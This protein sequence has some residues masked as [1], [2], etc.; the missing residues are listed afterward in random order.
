MKIELSVKE[1]E[2]LGH[3]HYWLAMGLGSGTAQL[4]N[5]ER[6]ELLQKARHWFERAYIY[7]GSAASKRFADSCEQTVSD[8][9]PALYA[10]AS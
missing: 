2:D 8:L 10:I 7:G 9:R 1:C 5:L 3:T 4:S 6:R